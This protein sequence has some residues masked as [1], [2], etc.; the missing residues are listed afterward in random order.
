MISHFYE[1]WECD[2]TKHLA[3]VTQ[4]HQELLLFNQFLTCSQQGQ[5]DGK[6]LDAFLQSSASLHP[7]PFYL[8]KKIFAPTSCV[9]K[10]R[11][12]WGT[13]RKSNQIASRAWQSTRFNKWWE[14]NPERIQSESWENLENALIKC[15]GGYCRCDWERETRNGGLY[16]ESIVA[17]VQNALGSIRWH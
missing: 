10:L 16:S 12:I 9:L 11:F 6:T 7:R 15:I 17:A 2:N 8:W 4:H 3:V 5:I 1:N 14:L 13:E